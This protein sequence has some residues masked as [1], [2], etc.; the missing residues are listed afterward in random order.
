MVRRGSTVRVRQRALQKP[1]ITE[2]FVSINLHVCERGAG[3]EPVMEPSGRKRLPR[4]PRF[5]PKSASTPFERRFREVLTRHR[6]LA[7]RLRQAA[8]RAVAGSSLARPSHQPQRSPL[9]AARALRR[10]LH[11][12]PTALR[13]NGS[14]ASACEHARTTRASFPSARARRRCAPRAIGRCGCRRGQDRRRHESAHRARARRG[15]V[16][17]RPRRAAA[18]RGPRRP[19]VDPTSLL[20][21]RGSPPWLRKEN[22]GPRTRNVRENLSATFTVDLRV[23]PPAIAAVRFVVTRIPRG[24]GFA[25]CRGAHVGGQLLG[26]LDRSRLSQPVCE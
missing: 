10:H 6:I 23:G 21:K 14:T 20:L 2:L 16:P 25:V 4:K 19:G 3:M 7:K 18:R 9:G 24:N 1:R 13:P 5:G 15:G 22:R 17:A 26:E 11:I 12:A 8:R